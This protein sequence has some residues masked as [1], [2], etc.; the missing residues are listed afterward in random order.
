MTLEKN[1]WSRFRACTTWA[2]LIR[3]ENWAENGTPDVNGCWQGKEFWV[4]LK[5]AELPKREITPVAVPHFTEDQRRWLH[6]RS[7]AG[8]N[9]YLLLQVEREYLLFKGDA[10]AIF[11]GYSTL[12]QLR[13]QAMACGLAAC[14]AAIKERGNG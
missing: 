11:V 1:L 9:A 4:E 3:V 2:H 14:A 7:V 12:N 13:H 5:V 8:G 10:A 6:N